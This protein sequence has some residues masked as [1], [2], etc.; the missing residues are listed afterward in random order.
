MIA[1]EEKAEQATTIPPAGS[2]E[3]IRAAYVDLVGVVPASI[4]FDE[5]VG[6]AELA[7]S[8]AGVPAYS[9]G[10][11]IIAELVAEQQQPYD[12]DA[13]PAST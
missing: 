8:T 9:L 3:R 2:I 6:V 13:S 5:L 7:M 10:V 4:G 1:A 12:Y 11:E